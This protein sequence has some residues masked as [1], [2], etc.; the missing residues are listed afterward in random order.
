MEIKLDLALFACQ[1]MLRQ[2]A[3]SAGGRQSGF[4]NHN[5]RT[6]HRIAHV[7]G[8]IADHET[9][10]ATVVTVGALWFRNGR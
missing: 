8:L 9:E 3:L 6:V 10:K 5:L 1:I 4:Q 7:P 2:S